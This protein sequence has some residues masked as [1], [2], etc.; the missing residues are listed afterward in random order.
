MSIA[1]KFN[2]LAMLR[3]ATTRHN[4]HLS[5]LVAETGLWAHPQVHTH[6]MSEDPAGTYFPGTRRYRA[7]AGERRGE[8]LAGERLDDNTYANHALKR[9]LGLRRGE[10]IGFEVC[11]VWPQ[12][13]YESRYHTAIANLVL[14]PRPLAGLSDH[15]PEIQAALQFRAFELYGWHPVDQPQPIRP[16]FYPEYWRQPMPFSGTVKRSLAARRAVHPGT[17]PHLGS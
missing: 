11:H 5:V 3:E 16:S 6:L 9:S 10:A 15:D 4:I 1:I 13:C 8:V 14:L 17:A 12:S 2:A 7:G